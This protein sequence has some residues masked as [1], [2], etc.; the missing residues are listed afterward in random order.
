VTEGL[1]GLLDDR[2]LFVRLAA[3]EAL[4]SRD[5]T[6]VTEGLLHLLGDTDR[7]VRATTARVLA[8]REGSGV[9]ESLLNLLGDADRFVRSTA[10][11][12]LASRDEA[13]LALLTWVRETRGP[14]GIDLPLLVD[15]AERLMISNFRRIEPSKQPEV[16]A[17]LA[18]LTALH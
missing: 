12:A 4:A 15:L 1:L 14:E 8:S 5:G 7:F 10:A 11:K 6:N 16:R 2:S 13:A 18:R 17:A 9:T 3:P